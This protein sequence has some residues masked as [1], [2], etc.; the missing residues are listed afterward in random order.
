[1]KEVLLKLGSGRFL[2]TVIVGVVFAYTAIDGTLPSE[3]TASIITAV[4]VAY[5]NRSDRADVE[6][7]GSLTNGN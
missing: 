6:K 5:F 3:A 4:I 7:K 1:M 2:L